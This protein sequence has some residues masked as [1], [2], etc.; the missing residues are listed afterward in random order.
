VLFGVAQYRSK[1]DLEMVTRDL[2]NL[3]TY[4]T[5]QGFEPVVGKAD[6]EVTVDPYR[7]LRD[8]GRSIR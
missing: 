6:A 5:R 1:R 8:A 7:A 4:L 3:K 2:A